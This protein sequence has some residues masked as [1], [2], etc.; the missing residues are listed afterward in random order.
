M[1]LPEGMAINPSAAGGLGACSPEQIGLGSAQVFGVE[2]LGGAGP[3]DD[4]DE[5]HADDPA[6][7][8]APA[9]VAP[10]AGRRGRGRS[11]QGEAPDEE[12]TRTDGEG[13]TTSHDPGR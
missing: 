9:L 13:S 5:E 7:L 3:A 12:S 4:V 11:G 8:A 2:L 10:A 6:L 1:R